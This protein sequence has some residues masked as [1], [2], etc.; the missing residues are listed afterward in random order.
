MK[1]FL[2]GKASAVVGTHTHIP[3]DDAEIVDGTAYI[4]DCGMT[5][6]FDSVIGVDKNIILK[7]FLTGFPARFEPATGDARLNGVLIEID[8]GKAVEIKKIRMRGA[9][10]K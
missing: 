4:T 5:G 3:T 7:R 8:G 2:A 9:K 1:W 6:P 10:R